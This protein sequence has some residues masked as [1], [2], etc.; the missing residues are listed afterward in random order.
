M[1]HAPIADYHGVEVEFAKRSTFHKI[2]RVFYKVLRSFY[3]GVIFYFI[4]FSVMWLQW[5]TIPADESETAGH[6]GGH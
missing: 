1:H 2:A 3:V 5:T 4:P 6:G